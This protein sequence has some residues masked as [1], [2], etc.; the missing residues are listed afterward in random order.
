[1]LFGRQV[2]LPHLPGPILEENVVFKISH[3][4]VCLKE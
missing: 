4:V 2:F 1:M 3:K